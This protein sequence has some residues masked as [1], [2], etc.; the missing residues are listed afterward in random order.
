MARIQW[1]LISIVGLA[2][3]VLLRDTLRSFFDLPSLMITVGG[4]LAATYF[5][6][7]WET[8]KGLVNVVHAI[9]T[10]T[11]VS[12]EAH[13]HKIIQLARL[14]H[15]GGLRALESHEQ[16]LQDPLLRRAVSM[17]VDMQREDEV[18]AMVEHEFF[19]FAHRYEASR[20]VLLTI[21]KLLPSFGMVGTLIGL[22]LLLRQATDPDPQT[23]APALAVA[24]LTTLYGA[25]FSNAL[26]LPLA[27]KL[28]VFIHDQEMLTRL[29]MEGAVLIARN[30]SPALVEKRIGLL[31]A[32][33][34]F[35]EQEPL[36][37]PKQQ[38]RLA[39]SHR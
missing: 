30:Q 21:G 12:L 3:I 14:N 29:T 20:Q 32:H 31:A 5:S 25:V 10:T 39:L 11:S 24:V 37:T 35:L 19:L 33:G 34:E 8:L 13:A 1:I 4:T 27:A 28:Q 6:Y 9:L 2:I 38:P 36:P 15:T 22:V 18:R 7:S 16:E 26:A 17:I 23:L